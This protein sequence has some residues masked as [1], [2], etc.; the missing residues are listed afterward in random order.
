MEAKIRPGLYVLAVSGGVDSMALL[1]VLSKQPAVNL[2]LAHFNHG[3]RPEADKDEKLV[4]SAAKRYGLPLEVGYGRLGPKASEATARNARYRFLDSVRQKHGAEAV[5]TAHHR[6]DLVETAILNLLRGT[7]SRGLI[8]MIANPL[9]VRPLLSIPKSQVIEYA[10]SNKLKWREDRTNQDTT[11][12]RN[13][14]RHNVV[15][16]MGPGNKESLLKNID[17]VANMEQEKEE[18][19]ATLSQKM[20]RKGVINRHNFINLPSA[21]SDEILLYWLR[22]SSLGQVDRPVIK[23]LSSLIKTAKPGKTYPINK[24]AYIEISLKTVLLRTTV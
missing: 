19:L 18:L 7:G 6:D 5:I 4:V 24:S 16:G 21:I 11:I 1:D 10:K 9:I 13:Y 20:F 14:I 15:A 3:I 12:A 2:T 23:K 17:K 8:S 22:K